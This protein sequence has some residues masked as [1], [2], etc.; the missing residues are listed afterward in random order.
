[1]AITPRRASVDMH[2]GELAADLQ[3]YVQEALD[4]GAVHAAVVPIA[5]IPVD[6][7]VVLKC[8]I[9]RCFGYGVSANCPPH[10]PTPAEMRHQ[11]SSYGWAV[12]FAVDVEPRVIVRDKATIVERI[13]AYQ[14]VYDIVNGLESRAFYD[15]HYLAFGLGAGSCR[16]TFCSQAKDCAAVKGER[17]RFPLK[18]RPSLE[19]VGID[20]YKMFAH[21][22]WEI[23]PA[24]S[25]M[26]ADDL[27]CGSLAGMVVVQ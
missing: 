19:A 9:P 6:D 25:D 10:A 13:A 18:S 17:C 14:T 20:V 5:D 8:R 3:R 23:Y 21:L 27:P 4:A 15:G 2:Q 12:F 11:L 22:G 7:R 1:M 16:H 26:K 24:G